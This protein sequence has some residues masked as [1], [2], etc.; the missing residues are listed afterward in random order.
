MHGSR[1]PARTLY[2]KCDRIDGRWKYYWPAIDLTGSFDARLERVTFCVAVIFFYVN[3]FLSRVEKRSLRVPSAYVI[4][5]IL[6]EFYN[7]FIAAKFR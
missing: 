2:N 6:L 3:N 4:V 5:I 7:T 1:A